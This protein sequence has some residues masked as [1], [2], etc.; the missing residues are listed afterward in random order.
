MVKGRAVAIC[1]R[2]SCAIS[3]VFHQLHHHTTLNTTETS[4]TSAC[5]HA[6]TKQHHALCM[7]TVHS[8]ERS[9]RFRPWAYLDMTTKVKGFAHGGDVLIWSAEGGCTLSHESRLLH[10]ITALHTDV[11][12][13]D[14]EWRMCSGLIGS[15][16]GKPRQNSEL[17]L[18]FK[19]SPEEATLLME[20]GMMTL[21]PSLHAR[22]YINYGS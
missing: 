16:P 3:V 11:V 12:K 17:G 18:P 9:N 20:K 8:P 4:M 10:N 6:L 2:T 14:R 13:L 22:T 5:M 1:W 21:G 19:L 15:L 7:L